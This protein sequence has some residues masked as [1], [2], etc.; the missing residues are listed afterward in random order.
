MDWLSRTELLLGSQNITKLQSS[1]VLVAGIGGVG[2]FAAELLVRAGIGELTIV[3]DDIIKASNR[4]R[5]LPALSITESMLKVEVMAE[6]LLLINPKLRLHPVNKFLKDENIS[7]LLDKG[8][9]SYV[10]D[11]IDSIT[12]KVKLIRE[13]LHRN[14]PLI[15][16]MGAGGKINP[17]L[18]RIEDISKTYNCKLAKAIRKGLGIYNIKKGLDVVFSPEGVNKQHLIYVDNELYKK[19]TLGTISYMPAIF[20]TL[21]CSVIIRKLIDIE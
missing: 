10:L 4:N 15:S 5:Q 1:H 7:E 19:T 21:A 8:S 12:P 13:S 3:D 14:L 6:R 2:S 20:G 9:F 18:V 16:S 11:A 17:A